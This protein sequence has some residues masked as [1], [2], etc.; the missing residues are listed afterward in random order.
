MD[1]LEKV[2]RK[3]HQAG[4]IGIP[5]SEILNEVAREI[6]D[7]NIKKC[8]HQCPHKHQTP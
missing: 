8:P 1:A 7:G 3:S 4:K 6:F 5:V 2:V